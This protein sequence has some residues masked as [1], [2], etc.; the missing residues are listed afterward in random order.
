MRR[1]APLRDSAGEYTV[2]SPRMHPITARMRRAVWRPGTDE[3][4]VF[5]ILALHNRLQIRQKCRSVVTRPSWFI[6]P[7][8]RLL[9]LGKVQMNLTVPTQQKGPALS[10]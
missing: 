10:C 8:L 9:A 5:H 3:I 7:S 2:T 6:S 1:R 4:Q